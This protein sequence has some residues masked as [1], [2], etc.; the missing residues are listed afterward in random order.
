MPQ[1]SQLSEVYLSQFLWLAVALGF[2]FFVIARG[3]VPKIQATV[4]TR[5]RTIASDLEAAQQARVAADDTEAQWRERMDA[6]RA[7]A[8]R[9]AQE[10]KQ[11]SARDTEAKVKVA[12]DKLT[13]KVEAAEAK[14]RSACESARAEIEAVAAE[15][16]REMVARLTGIKVEAKEAAQAVKAELN[17]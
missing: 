13:R 9:I 11:A 2:I 6:A 15:A 8:A 17:V 5:E 3:M 7:E 16:T 14:I 12:A 1:L 10:A 4:E